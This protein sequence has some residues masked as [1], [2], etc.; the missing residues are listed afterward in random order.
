MVYTGD[1]LNNDK[2]PK[3]DN[4]YGTTKDARECRDICLKTTGCGW[5]NWDN[6]SCYLKKSK[7]KK[8]EKA[9][10]VSG[11]RSCDEGTN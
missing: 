2:N 4:N 9:K 3:Q 1:P 7:G 10:G 8:K 6:G 5:F 11:P